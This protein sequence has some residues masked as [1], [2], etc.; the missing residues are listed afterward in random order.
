[1][2]HEQPESDLSFLREAA[3]EMV[4]KFNVPPETPLKDPSADSV[5]P[6]EFVPPADHPS[7]VIHEDSP[8]V[9]AGA[10]D[11]VN[12]DKDMVQ[13]DNP[14]GVLSSKDRPPAP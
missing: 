2:W 3:R 9:N 12:E 10:N 1:M 8:M 13:I 4:A 7:Q 14:L 11:G 5:I 6:A